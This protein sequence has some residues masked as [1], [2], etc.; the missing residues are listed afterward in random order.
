MFENP[1][2]MR[3]WPPTPLLNVSFDDA[4]IKAS[5]ASLV[6]YTHL[7]KFPDV[8]VQRVLTSEKVHWASVVGPAVGAVQIWSKSQTRKRPVY[9]NRD[10]AGFQDGKLKN[11]CWRRVAA[12]AGLWFWEAQ[13]MKWYLYT[14]RISSE[15]AGKT[16]K[17]IILSREE[18][19]MDAYQNHPGSV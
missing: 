11:F 12:E 18:Y 15:L 17:F 3:R 10:T 9:L 13:L 14:P 1:S 7:G 4:Q 2:R 5:L 16:A 6:S 19:T 8:V